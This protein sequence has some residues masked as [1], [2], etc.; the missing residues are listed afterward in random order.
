MKKISHFTLD[1][2]MR[3]RTSNN[4]HK[5]PDKNNKNSKRKSSQ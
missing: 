2:I 5:Q 3:R 4:F 1:D